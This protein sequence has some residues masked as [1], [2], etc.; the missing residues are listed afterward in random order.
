MPRAKVSSALTQAVSHRPLTTQAQ[1]LSINVPCSSSSTCCSYLIDE[2]AK[3]GNVPKSNGLSEIREHWIET[4]IHSLHQYIVVL[5][6]RSVKNA[7]A[8]TQRTEGY[9]YINSQIRA[10]IHVNVQ[11]TQPYIHMWPHTHTHIYVNIYTRTHV[12]ICIAGIKN[13][14]EIYIYIYIYSYIYIYTHTRTHIYMCIAGIKYFPEI[15]DT[16]QNFVHR[17]SDMKQVP[18][19]GP[20]DIRRHHTNFS[21]QAICRSEFVHPSYTSGQLRSLITPLSGFFLIIIM[22]ISGGPAARSRICYSESLRARRFGVRTR[23]G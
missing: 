20:T 2:R 6:L 8:H 21:A 15:Q 16:T 10:S 3:P 13:V 5:T 19:L 4:Y 7:N 17:K 9:T 18:Y 12:Y 23:W 1:V 14:P 22:M 11:D